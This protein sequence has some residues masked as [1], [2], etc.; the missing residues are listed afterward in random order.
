MAG[1]RQD[2]KTS[3]PSLWPRTDIV[4]VKR[5]A[6][7]TT[8]E[9]QKNTKV[10]AVKYD[11]GPDDLQILQMEERQTGPSS[12]TSMSGKATPEVEL[13]PGD[14]DKQLQ[15]RVN[16][17]ELELSAQFE[18]YRRL[19]RPEANETLLR[20]TWPRLTLAWIEHEKKAVKIELEKVL[21]AR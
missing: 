8:Q 11:N 2:T 13:S 18:R 21:S 5:G 14:I 16:E 17:L 9:E 6:G 12:A 7:G 4:L 3:S 15:K 19:E 20:D 10:V 1:E